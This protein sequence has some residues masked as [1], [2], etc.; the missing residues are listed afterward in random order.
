M[1]LATYRPEVLRDRAKATGARVHRSHPAARWAATRST[2]CHGDGVVA[3]CHQGNAVEE[4][5]S[6]RA[7]GIRREPRTFT[8]RSDRNLFSSCHGT[9]RGDFLTSMSTMDLLE[10]VATME[11]PT[12]VMVGTRDALTLPNKA[13][14]IA[15][16]VPGARLVTLQNRRDMLPLEDP[17]PL[18][19]RSC[20]RSRGE[21]NAFR[22]SFPRPAP[23]R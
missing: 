23:G 14:Q 5:A 13:E 3:A 22:R 11:V 10:G 19:M 21:C 12:T 2:G 7:V 17:T 8:R 20:G 6:P 9:V 18:P 16:T 15:A 1:S 4:R